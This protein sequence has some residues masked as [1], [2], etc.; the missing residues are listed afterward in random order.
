MV[1]STL[2]AW[3]VDSD[4]WEKV[5]SNIVSDCSGGSDQGVRGG[6]EQRVAECDRVESR[7]KRAQLLERKQSLGKHDA[8]FPSD[9]SLFAI[10]CLLLA[11]V[12]WE[13][14]WSRHQVTQ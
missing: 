1:W 5:V 10:H 6:H 8:N 2:G 14:V 9:P 11:R 12:R 7:W 3:K 4:E 13:Q